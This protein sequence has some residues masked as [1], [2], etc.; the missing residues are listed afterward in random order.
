MNIDEKKFE[1][2]MA[3]LE[4]KHPKKAK[5]IKAEKVAKEKKSKNKG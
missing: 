4:K 3:R 2:I 1:Y 5:E